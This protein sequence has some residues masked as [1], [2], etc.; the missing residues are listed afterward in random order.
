MLNM[1]EIIK[2]FPKQ[3]EYKPEIVN[4]Q[5]LKKFDSFVVVGMGGSHLA[6]G[7]LKILKP[8]LKIVIHKNYGLPNI[9]EDVLNKSLI[10]LN[11]Y[12]GNTEEVIDAFKKA[13]NRG[14][15]LA[16]VSKNGKLI[17]LAQEDNIPYI[18]IPD[19]GIQPRFALG[20]SF[21][22]LL[23][24]MGQEDYLEK[25]ALLS[26]SLNPEKHK[27]CGKDLADK[28]KGFIPVIYASAK[29]EYLAYIWKVKFNETVQIPAFWNTFPELNHN[30]IV[31]FNNY[32][33]DGELSKKFYFIFLKDK[34]DDQKIIKRMDVLKNLYEEQ[35]FSVEM[36]EINDGE[37]LERV[38]SVVILSD[39][40]SFHLA[41]RYN[42]DY[43][44]KSVIDKFKELIK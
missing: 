34:D 32:V 29:N 6:A 19:T 38:F 28:I 20:F 8:E 22:A 16:I 3:F 2:N 4:G 27:N 11:S 26:K 35:G 14:L 15:E 9:S 7:V 24:I 25:A 43:G 21:L 10:I 36:V 41:E 44:A 37:V 31:G 5:N 30:E 23:K 40:V 13:R 39:W 17:D 18:Q 42:I 33:L 1:T 12:S